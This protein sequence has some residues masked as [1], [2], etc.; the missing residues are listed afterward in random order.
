MVVERD[1]HVVVTDARIV[2]GTPDDVIAEIR[3]LAEAGVD[4]VRLR[5]AR[6]PADLTAITESVIPRASAAGILHSD[7]E[8]PTLRQRLGLPRRASRYAAQEVSA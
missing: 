5:P 3:A 8:S 7:P 2:V 4:G 1:D 6:L